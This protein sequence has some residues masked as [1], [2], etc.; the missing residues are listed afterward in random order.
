[1]LDSL[2][3]QHQG[4][5]GGG[6]E[7]PILETVFELNLEDNKRTRLLHDNK[8]NKKPEYPTK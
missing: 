6:I 1:M 2:Q 7:S 3:F 5:A 8:Y 4:Q